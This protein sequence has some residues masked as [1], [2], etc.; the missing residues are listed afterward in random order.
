MS[1]FQVRQRK[2]ESLK[3]DGHPYREESDVLVR[4][5]D[6]A[7]SNSVVLDC[8][9]KVHSLCGA[10][11]VPSQPRTQGCHCEQSFTKHGGHS[12]QRACERVCEVSAEHSGG[13]AIVDEAPQGL[14]WG[15]S[16]RRIQGTAAAVR[17]NLME[18]GI[19][20]KGS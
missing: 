7:A 14:G 4:M 13:W 3:A 10:R 2:S 8:A 5:S 11:A 15:A 18:G 20:E 1:W 17:L 19:E 16:A 9:V 6:R 12:T